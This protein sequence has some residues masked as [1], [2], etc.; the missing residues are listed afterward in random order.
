MA[1]DHDSIAFAT[2]ALPLGAIYLLDEREVGLQAP[3]VEEVA[4]SDALA[5]LVANTYVN[6]LLDRDMRSSE[7]D[8]LGRLVTK[9]PVRRVRP[10]AE[11][12]AV[13]DLCEIIAADAKRV[14]ISNAATSTAKD[15][16][17]DV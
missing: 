3:I 8:L 2:K 1:L 7:F 5:G 10:L 4:G 6:Y 17:S 14:M 11:P 15:D 13:F 16:I 12:A 9:T